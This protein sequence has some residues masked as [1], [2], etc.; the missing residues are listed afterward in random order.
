MA[1][2][3]GQVM[4][5]KHFDPSAPSDP[6]RR[7]FTRG[8]LAAPVLLGSLVSQPVLGQSAYW[9]SPSGGTSGNLSTHG[10]AVSCI[11]GSS[12]TA[13]ESGKWPTG[14]TADTIFNGWSAGTTT[15]TS[16]I[17]VAATSS[18]L[19][20]AFYKFDG[21][22]A[23]FKEV[24]KSQTSAS[25]GPRGQL[26]VATVASLLNALNSSSYPVSSARVV[27]MFNATH[28][29]GA[30]KVNGIDWYLADV[31]KYFRSLYQ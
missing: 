14:L 23:T 28:N 29:G 15:L 17:F 2:A 3:E 9:C 31:L 26:G 4:K 27:A 22:A 10:P 12:P 30:Y 1:I 13:W 7:R 25:T 19:A 6:G 24:L 5:Q 16:G 20:N 21:K 11:S 8:G 18:S